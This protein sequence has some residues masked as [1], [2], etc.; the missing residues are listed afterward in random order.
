MFHGGNTHLIK[1][2]FAAL[3]V[4]YGRLVAIVLE[5][6]GSYQTITT[7]VSRPAGDKDARTLVQWMHAINSLR[8]G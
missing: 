2:V 5:M 8:Y 6:A 4:V 7:V 1:L 3:W